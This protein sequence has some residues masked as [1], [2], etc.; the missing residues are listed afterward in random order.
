[1]YT[2]ILASA[3]HSFI[4][5][6]RRRNP[7]LKEKIED[8]LDLLASNPFHPMLQS[9]KANTRKHGKRWSSHVS[10]DIRII[11]DF[12]ETMDITIDVLDIG[13]HSGSRGVYH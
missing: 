5:K 7:L 2:I 6:L 4:K 8:A 13:G 3:C 9:H 11:W 12:S 1:M 10:G